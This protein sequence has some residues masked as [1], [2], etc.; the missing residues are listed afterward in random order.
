M[1]P[2]ARHRILA[3]FVAGYPTFND[4]L[5][6]ARGLIAGGA[7]A[8][9]MQIPFTDPSAD[10]PDIDQACQTALAG[11]FTFN[12]A[13][14]LL[15]TIRRESDIPVFVM[16]YA[17]IAVV[18][19][20]PS[21]VRQL[22]E[23]GASGF[24]IPDLPPDS[25]EGLY[26]AAADVGAPA[27]PVIVPWISNSRLNQILALKPEMIYVALRKGITGQKTHIDTGQRQFLTQ[28]TNRPD[29][30]RILAGF[31]IQNAEQVREINSLAHAAV[32]GSA[33]ICK[34]RDNPDQRPGTVA[35]SFIQLLRGASRTCS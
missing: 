9:E 31:G 13:L 27:V 16:S 32:V 35:Q 2:P 20:I 21:F 11:G 34:V 23:Q 8:L 33:I 18:R 3:H 15:E 14:K 26:Q 1:I 4:S 7:W 28:L 24:I 22:S 12:D 5:D 17:N 29:A 25:D 6:I 19:G 30:P 10:G